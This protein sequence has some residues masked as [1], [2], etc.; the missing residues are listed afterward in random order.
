[1]HFLNLQIVFI[2]IYLSFLLFGRLTEEMNI[3]KITF[4]PPLL[5]PIARF[6][7]AATRHPQR[8]HPAEKCHQGAARLTSELRAHAH[9]HILYMPHL[10]F[11]HTSIRGVIAR[12]SVLWR[13]KH[14]NLYLSFH[15]CCLEGKDYYFSHFTDEETTTKQMHNKC[16]EKE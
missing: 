16:S 7:T 6:P 14:N 15:I 4:L 10:C 8:H 1:M 11:R 9:M 13:T 3:L 5:T 12:G 2:Y